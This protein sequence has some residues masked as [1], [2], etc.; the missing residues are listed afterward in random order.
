MGYRK[1]SDRKGVFF[2]KKT[3]RDRA[4]VNRHR[5]PGMAQHD[6]I[7]QIMDAI[8]G[9]A[10]GEYLQLFHRFPTHQGGDQPCQS[11]YMI[12]M[13]MRD[14]NTVE[15]FKSNARLKNLALRTFATVDQ[16]AVFIML[17]HLGR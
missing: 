8:D 6:A 7:N 3:R 17:N 1:S 11:E 16:E 15:A 12:E 2:N 9:A 10:P 4:Q 13:S 14:Q 5:R